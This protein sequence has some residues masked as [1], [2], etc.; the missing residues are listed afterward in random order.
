MK[1]IK[2]YTFLFER[3]GKADLEDQYEVQLSS[4][5][6]FQKRVSL[7]GARKTIE[8]WVNGDEFW[9]EVTERCFE[10]GGCVYECPVCTC[11]TVM[12][13]RNGAEVERTRLWDACLFKGFTRMAGNILP[14]EDRM[15]RTKRWFYHKLMHYPETL[16]AFGCVGCGRCAVTCPGRIDMAAV[17]SRMKQHER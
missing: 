6:M 5:A 8:G 11:F 9:R 17:V 15:L 10:C 7:E 3:V 1:W 12:D 2:G 14:S 16:G 13:R 4:Q